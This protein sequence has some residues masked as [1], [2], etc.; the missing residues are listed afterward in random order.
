[1]MGQEGG[2]RR[3]PRAAI[4]DYI[5][6]FYNRRRLHSALAY[7]SPAQYESQAA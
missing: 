7:L 2:T 1:M 3:L 4:F 6:G 5:E